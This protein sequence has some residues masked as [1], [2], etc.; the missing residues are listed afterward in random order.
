MQDGSDKRTKTLT[1]RDDTSD[2]GRDKAPNTTFVRPDPRIAALVRMLARRAAERDFEQ[3][4]RRRD[5]E[6]RQP[7]A[8]KQP[9]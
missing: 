2:T 8:G 9:T 1:R 3:L 4:L 5:R 7:G 6:H